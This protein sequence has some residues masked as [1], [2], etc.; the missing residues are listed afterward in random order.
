MGTVHRDGKPPKRMLFKKVLSFTDMEFN[1]DIITKWA[2]EHLEGHM[3]YDFIVFNGSK[4]K[5]NRNIEFTAWF[6][7]K[8]D[9]ERFERAWFK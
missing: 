4:G 5:L 1:E 9:A 6:L 7:T 2:R 8:T 3:Q